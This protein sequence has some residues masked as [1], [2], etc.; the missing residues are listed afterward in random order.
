[1]P[2][3]LALAAPAR[4]V[5]RLPAG[6]VV[7]DLVRD[8]HVPDREPPP[9]AAGDADQQHHRHPELVPKTAE[10]DGGRTRSPVERLRRD[11]AEIAALG[12]NRRVEGLPAA[13]L[14]PG[15]EPGV[16]ESAGVPISC[17]RRPSLPGQRGLWRHGDH[18]GEKCC[19]GDMKQPNLFM[20]I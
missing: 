16:G 15:P 2:P 14:L 19:Q 7:D 20:S 17:H 10:R 1:V 8:H 12:R 11:H 9:D 4:S 3:G 5:G 13:R 18:P 6:V